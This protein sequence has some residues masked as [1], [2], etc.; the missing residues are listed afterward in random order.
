MKLDL[1]DLDRWSNG[2]VAGA[3]EDIDDGLTDSQI[4]WVD[5]LARSL[6]MTGNWSTREREVAESILREW[7][8][9]E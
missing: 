3:L 2:D 5:R 9:G 6:R 8:R 7:N 4:K 1:D